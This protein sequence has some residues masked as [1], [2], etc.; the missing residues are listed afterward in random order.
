MDWV[1]PDTD[2]KVRMGLQPIE[3][4]NVAGGS[5]ILDT[6]A[7]AAVTLNWQFSE[8]VG[9][10]LMWGR[11]YNDNY[12]SVESGHGNDK[13]SYLDNI[14]LIALSVPLT[15]DGVEL[16]P[17]VMYGL[18]GQNAY[19]GYD[20]GEG[21]TDL[22]ARKMDQDEPGRRHAWT[23]AF[24]A[25]LPIQLSFLEPLNIEIDINYGFAESLGSMEAYKSGG[26]GPRFA[27]T[28]REGWLV[29]ALIE[30]QTDWGTPG[31]FGWYASGDDGNP[32]NGSERLPS[33]E[34]KG[35]FTSIMGDDNW[36]WGSNP[37]LYDRTLNYAGTWGIGLQLRDV[38]LVED[39][40]HT[41]RVA[42]WG[43]TNSPEMAVYASPISWQE[44]VADGLYLTRN[45]GL[46][47]FN[48]INR[49]EMYEN[50]EINLELGYLANFVDQDTWKKGGSLVRAY[51]K[52]DAWKAQLIFAYTF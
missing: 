27:D 31:L 34:A 50:M 7:L 30:Y 8:N 5:S 44:G 40:S 20:Q 32:G 23:S 28:R 2:L 46:L 19:R 51:E 26:A 22:Y 48:L 6:D 42:Y 11:P 49:Y 14:D 15:F 52:Q 39:L 33:I 43:G 18:V 35:N 24:W 37:D 12:T 45:D 29:K 16:T 21:P 4:P 36:G 13:T 17:W 25:G 38:S 47:E 10:T 9:A 3:L 1:V 41:F